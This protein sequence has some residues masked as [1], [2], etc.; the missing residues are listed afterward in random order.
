MVSLS[1]GGKVGFGRGLG[2]FCCVFSVDCSC[3]ALFLFGESFSF[4]FFVPWHDDI[5]KVIKRRR[6]AMELKNVGQTRRGLCLHYGFDLVRR[7]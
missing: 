7:D 2:L 4:Y 6:E 1:G 3:S 5:M